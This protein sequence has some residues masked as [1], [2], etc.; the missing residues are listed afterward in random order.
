MVSQLKPS[1]I[2]FFSA[3]PRLIHLQVRGH[4]ESWRERVKKLTLAL[5]LIRLLLSILKLD[6]RA[7]W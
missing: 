5:R 4:K 2:K 1:Y 6:E 3:F 7:F